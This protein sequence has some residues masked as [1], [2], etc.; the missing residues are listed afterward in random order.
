MD[1]ILDLLGDLFAPGPT[2]TFPTNGGTDHPDMGTPMGT[3]PSSQNDT[4]GQEGQ[5]GE[6]GHEDNSNGDFVGGVDGGYVI[7][8]GAGEDG[9]LV[10]EN[11]VIPASFG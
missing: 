1:V 9:G 6:N 5:D 3:D 11:P 2:A 7:A 8:G 10:T 4:S